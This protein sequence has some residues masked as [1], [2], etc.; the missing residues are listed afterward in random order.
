MELEAGPRKGWSGLGIYQLPDVP[1]A[2]AS[3]PRRRRQTPALPRV[4]AQ[5]KQQLQAL[6]AAAD[7]DDVELA[8][9]R[10]ELS[11]ARQDLEAA[12]SEAVLLR[13]KL[14]DAAACASCAEQEAAELRQQLKEAQRSASTEAA[15]AQVL[16]AAV[17]QAEAQVADVSREAAVAAEEARH[18]QQTQ[19]EAGLRLDKLQ[20]QAGWLNAQVE[21]EQRRRREAEAEAG[22]QK[23]QA[24]DAASAAEQARQQCAEAQNAA[25]E[26]KAHIQEERQQRLEVEMALAAGEERTRDAAAKAEHVQQ[27]CATAQAEA[28]ELRALLAQERRQRAEMEKLAA[29]AAKQRDCSQQQLLQE[30][31]AQLEGQ[32][33][34]LKTQLASEQQWC[35]ALEARAA[36][37]Q[38]QLP[39]GSCLQAYS[40]APAATVFEQ[41][42][43]A[44][45]AGAAAAAAEASAR[46]LLLAQ[47]ENGALRQRFQTTLGQLADFKVSL[48]C[49][50][51]EAEEAEVEA[52]A[53]RMEAPVWE[54]D[55]RLAAPSCDADEGVGHVGSTSAGAAAVPATAARLAQLEQQLQEADEERATEAAAAREAVQKLMAR[56]AAMAQ[57]GQK[58]LGRQQRRAQEREQQLQAA[59]DAATAQA[60]ESCRSAAAAAAQ[61]QVACEQADALRASAVAELAAVQAAAAE[62]EQHLLAKGRQ[63]EAAA[64]AAVSQ[65]EARV[66]ALEAQAGGGNGGSG[67]GKLAVAQLG[68]NIPV[69]HMQTAAPV[70]CWDWVGFTY[71]LT[72]PWIPSLPVVQAHERA[73]CRALHRLH[74]QLEVERQLAA[75]VK[76]NFVCR[77]AR[78]RNRWLLHCCVLAWRCMARPLGCT[79]S[80][81]R[82][83]SARIPAGAAAAECVA[84]A[85]AVAAPSRM[86]CRSQLLG[87]RSKPAGGGSTSAPGMVCLRSPL[88]SDA[89][90]APRDRLPAC[91][92]STPGFLAPHMDRQMDAKVAASSGSLS[93]GSIAPAGASPRPP[94]PTAQS[95]PGLE[96]GQLPSCADAGNAQLA[97]VAGTVGT[98]QQHSGNS[99]LWTTA[100]TETAEA[101]GSVHT[102]V[103]CMSAPRNGMAAV[104]AGPTAAAAGSTVLLQSSEPAAPSCAAAACSPASRRAPSA[105]QVQWLKAAL[106]AALESSS[107]GDDP[108]EPAGGCAVHSSNPNA[109]A[110]AS[111]VLPSGKLQH[112]A[113]AASAGNGKGAPRVGIPGT[114][115]E[116]PTALAAGAS[117]ASFGSGTS[118]RALATKPRRSAS[119]AGSAQ[120]SVPLQ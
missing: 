3:S 62:R 69:Q 10:D 115:A 77:V 16:A 93:A 13:R 119:A 23:Q 52:A 8:R 31:V 37:A 76:R 65:L 9:R 2:R 17:Q 97:S 56:C 60:A 100:S 79:P 7:S 53:A 111:A 51:H 78:W 30:R 116:A 40:D 42:V 27:E 120:P 35:S 39:M 113:R 117:R 57:E 81:P 82:A 24:R 107:G 95:T 110:Q 44:A 45:A 71:P 73:A 18:H 33:E 108:G 84:E 28:A 54:A 90:E 91:L 85:A 66:A 59:L 43:T 67:S 61:R 12:L 25:A 70:D 4:Q 75:V 102:D 92:R 32:V 14:T 36:P 47:E 94:V 74:E 87:F 64:R 11:A 96:G 19:A 104:P 88:A 105:E 112:S 83:V 86:A 103:V 21:E 1:P 72:L 101:A 29:S 98:F 80:P 118:R 20:D 58:A 48:D 49:A 6:L 114:S 38:Q 5:W 89:A 106:L 41:A 99:S 34:S 55:C 22:A 26:L 15:R 46:G 68:R 109:T 63:L 50:V